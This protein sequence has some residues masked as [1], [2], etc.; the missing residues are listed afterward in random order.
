MDR[1]RFMKRALIS[2]SMT[3]RRS[4]MIS[5][6]SDNRER[7]SSH[8]GRRQTD[9]MST[10]DMVQPTP[11]IFDVRADTRNSRFREVVLT[12]GCARQSPS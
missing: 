2:E 6:T 4:A 3:V 7:K 9:L 11:E 10:S 8:G 5:T 1:E 12:R